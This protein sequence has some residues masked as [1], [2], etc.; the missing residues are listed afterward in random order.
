MFILILYYFSKCIFYLYIFC[1]YVY[2]YTHLL[3]LFLNFNIT[4]TFLTLLIL[5]INKYRNWSCTIISKNAPHHIHPSFFFYA[6]LV[7]L[8]L[9]S[10]CYNKDAAW[11][12]FCFTINLKIVFF[13][14]LRWDN[15]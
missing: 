15:F 8:F 14:Q 13:K 6:L 4:Y 9:T 7:L 11:V 3:A 10:V 1:N 12:R 2:M 5:F